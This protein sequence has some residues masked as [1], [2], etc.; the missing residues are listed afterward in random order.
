[1]T[2]RWIAIVVLMLVVAAVMTGSA[3]RR[4][5]TPISG[6]AVVVTPDSGAT[7]QQGGRGPDVP[8]R[9][10]DEINVGD[11][12]RTSQPLTLLTRDE[13]MLA[14]ARDSSL[15]LTRFEYGRFLG[16]QGF[17][18]ELEGTLR[19]DTSKLQ[20]NKPVRVKTPSA[21]VETRGTGF[22]VSAKPLTGTFPNAR[23]NPGRWQ[24]IIDVYKG[25]VRVANPGASAVKW[26]DIFQN[27]RRTV[28]GD[29]QPSAQAPFDP[30]SFRILLDETRARRE[31]GFGT[32]PEDPL[33]GSG[34]NSEDKQRGGAARAARTGAIIGGVAGGGGYLAGKLMQLAK[35]C[36]TQ[37][38][39]PAPYSAFDTPAERADKVAK[40]HAY[41]EC[42]G[43]SKGASLGVISCP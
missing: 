19:I 35:D 12:V 1:M 16:F 2:S 30:E 21:V 13:S 26:E 6:A 36:E 38:P 34:G 43:L 10:A 40:I 41:C 42:K 23:L 29:A 33:I 17:D 4:G 20:K 25:R 39:L 32:F 22:I 18:V 31:T 37:S 15:T 24:T 3:Q 14:L 11:V 5:R 8:L 28:Y 7:V 27:H 9:L